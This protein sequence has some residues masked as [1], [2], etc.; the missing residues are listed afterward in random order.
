MFNKQFTPIDEVV[1]N[2]GVPEFRFSAEGP[3]DQCSRKTL[4][5]KNLKPLNLG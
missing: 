2:D 1:E 4:Q 5:T 3:F